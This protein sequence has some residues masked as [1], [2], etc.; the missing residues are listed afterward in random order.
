[1]E[2][3]F[4]ACRSQPAASDG[5]GFETFDDSGPRAGGGREQPVKHDAEAQQLLAAQ[6]VAEGR[7]HDRQRM[8]EMR[9]DAL[10]NAALVQRFPHARQIEVLQVAKAAVDDLV[11][12]R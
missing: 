9:S 1:M 12:V 3:W 6:T 5:A 8:H 7:H 10:E 4:R 2:V 11:I